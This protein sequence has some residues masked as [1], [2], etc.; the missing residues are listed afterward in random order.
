MS[1]EL[2]RD[3][4]IGNFIIVFFVMGFFGIVVYL[5]MQ[6]DDPKKAQISEVETK[7]LLELIGEV[8]PL[9]PSEARTAFIDYVG[10]AV[11]DDIITFTEQDEIERLAELAKAASY[12]S[13]IKTKI[14]KQ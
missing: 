14:S 4:N 2:S 3:R 7:S 6:E 12:T 9:N 10:V 8:Q 13:D 5:G 11:K 1:D